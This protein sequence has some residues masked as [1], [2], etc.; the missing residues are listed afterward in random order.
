MELLELAR[1]HGRSRARSW[2][3]C[4]ALVIAALALGCSKQIPCS[5]FVTERPL[6][7]ALSSDDLQKVMSWIAREVSRERQPYCFRQSYGRGVG[8]PMRCPHGKAYDAGLCYRPCKSGYKGVG[9]VCWQS[10]LPG[11]AD[12]GAF[13]GKPKPYGRGV[14]YPWKFGDGFGDRGMRRRCQRAHPQGCEKKGLIYYPKCKPGFHSVGCC[15]CSPNC[16]PGQTD[17]GVSCAKKKYGRGVGKPVSAC[18][19]DQ[20]KDALLCY[21]KCRRG[22]RGVGPVCWQRC[23]SGRVD[24]AAGCATSKRACVSDTTKM[25]VKPLM[26]AVNIATLGGSSSATTAANAASKLGKIKRLMKIVDRE[27]KGLRE[28]A[29]W[30]QQRG[31]AVYQLHNTTS[32][33]VEDYVGSFEEMTTKRVARELSKHFCGDALLWIKQQYALSHLTLIMKADGIETAQNTLH[34]ISTFDPTGVAGVIDAFAKPK[35]STDVPFPE[36]TLLPPYA[37][38]R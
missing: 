22:F 30:A 29:K 17:I 23:P 31:T 26:L 14:G 35:C 37:Q 28:S 38:R 24:C 25:V 5:S 6:P 9:P 10:C 4:L 32:M 36:V 16:P 12:H 3:L 7:A 13:C 33:W 8:K 18:A 1:S 2:D 21:P 34:V 19:S 15:I 27:T 11:F 20:E